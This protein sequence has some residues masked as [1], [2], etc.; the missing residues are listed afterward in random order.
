[1]DHRLQALLCWHTSGNV[2]Q[3]CGHPVRSS[4]ILHLR[5][6]VLRQVIQ[7][8]TVLPQHQG[9]R[10]EGLRWRIHQETNHP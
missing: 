4:Q 8:T 7:E 1:M 6:P 3:A 2:P 5:F 10:Q 9:P